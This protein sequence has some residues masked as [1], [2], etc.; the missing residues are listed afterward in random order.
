ML[1]PA[2][3]SQMQTAAKEGRELATRQSGQTVKVIAIL[4]G[5]DSKPMPIAEFESPK[6]HARF[7]GEIDRVYA[8]LRGEI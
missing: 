7:A 4:R 8:G 6:A 1:L 3:L 2:W 5:G